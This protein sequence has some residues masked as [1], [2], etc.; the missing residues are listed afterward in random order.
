MEPK[1]ILDQS[2]VSDSELEISWIVYDLHIIEYQ[3]SVIS[4]S[5]L[6]YPNKHPKIIGKEMAKHKVVNINFN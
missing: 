4:S 2:S 3:V 6:Q 1:D 5:L